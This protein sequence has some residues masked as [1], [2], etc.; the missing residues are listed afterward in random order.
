[1]GEAQAKNDALMR[2]AAD[3]ELQC[4]AQLL[5]EHADAAYQNEQGISPL[6]AAAQ[7]GQAQARF[8]E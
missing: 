5:S 2:A 7:A 6:M 1:M 3:G 4:I 8:R